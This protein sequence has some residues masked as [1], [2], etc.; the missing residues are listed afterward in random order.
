MEEVSRGLH[1]SVGLHAMLCQGQKKD[2]DYPAQ[3]QLHEALDHVHGDWEPSS[4]ASGAWA[5]GPGRAALQAVDE[6]LVAAA[7]V[8]G[9]TAPATASTAA[10]IPPRVKGHVTCRLLLPRQGACQ[11]LHFL[12]KPHMSWLRQ[13]PSAQEPSV[14]P[15]KSQVLLSGT[16]DDP[17]FCP[18]SSL[19]APPHQSGPQ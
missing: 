13:H 15:E 11:G 16:Q 5:E 9:A 1:F 8:A 4:L 3:A 18:H 19:S 12:N 2:C 7:P 14:G 10:G 6:N 17:I